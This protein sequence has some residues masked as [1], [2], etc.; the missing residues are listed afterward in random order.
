MIRT[1]ALLAALVAAPAGAQA[2][3]LPQPDT[4]FYESVN[5]YRMYFVGSR[6]DTLGTPR[7][8]ASVTR[9][10]WRTDGEGLRVEQRQD[11]LQVRPAVRSE[12]FELTPRGVVRSID[13]DPDKEKGQ[14]DLVLRLPAD[15]DLRVGRVWHDTVDQ[16]RPVPGGEYAYQAVR[17][18]RVERMVDTLGGRMAVV[19]GTGRLR[20]RQTEPMDSTATRFWWMDVEGRWTRPFSSTCGAGGWRPASGGWTCAAPASFP[21][22]TA[23]W[24]PSPPGCCPWTPRA[25]SAPSAPG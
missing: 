15:G 5:P 2:R 23:A 4:L 9:Q 1:V 19:R 8:E 16:S 22:G 10:V 14:L 12:V 13:G 17:E 20:Y 24:T 7:R 18:L 3:Y 11:M 21:A 25:W 6:G